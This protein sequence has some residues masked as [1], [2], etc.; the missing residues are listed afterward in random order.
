VHLEGCAWNVMP[1]VLRPRLS[2]RITLIGHVPLSPTSSTPSTSTHFSARE[3]PGSVGGKAG[4]KQACGLH[5]FD[6]S[7]L[8]AKLEELCV[9]L[10]G[11][12]DEHAVEAG[13]LLTLVIE[14]SNTVV[15]LRMLPM[16]DI[17]QLLMIAQ[18][19]MAL[20]L[21]PGIVRGPA[22]V[23]VASSHPACHFFFFWL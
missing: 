9:H 23:P 2:G 19:V 17:P 22:V 1:S 14:A 8:L 6:G 21:V 13:E 10:A 4:G 15:D 20:V 18:E 7:D 5:S 16:W 12:E 3:G 11:V